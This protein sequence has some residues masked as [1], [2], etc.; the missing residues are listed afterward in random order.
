MIPDVGNIERVGG[1][2]A[3]VNSCIKALIHSS[4]H[5]INLQL[6]L[7]FSDFINRIPGMM[8]TAGIVFLPACFYREELGLVN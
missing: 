1:E 7:H 6:T 4:N 5:C 2:E 8:P 3:L